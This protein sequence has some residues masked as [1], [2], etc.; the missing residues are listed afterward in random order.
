M[1]A[2]TSTLLHSF[3]KALSAA[4][5]LMSFIYFNKHFLCFWVII[6]VWVPN[7]KTKIGHLNELLVS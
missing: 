7:E 4:S 3:T 6:L 5:H 2:F 1:C